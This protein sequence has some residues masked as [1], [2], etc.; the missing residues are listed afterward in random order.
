V[1]H[2][3]CRVS[4]ADQNPD[5]QR[6]ALLRA[7]VHPDQLY[8]DRTSG[9]KSSR[10]ARDALCKALRAGDVLVATRLDRVGRSTTHLVTLLDQLAGRGVAFRFL[11]QGIDTTTSEGRLMYRMLAAIA[12]FQRDL[13]IANTREGLA[14]ARARGR[15]GGRKPKLTGHQVQ[16]AQQLYDARDKTVA[17]IAAIFTVPRTTIYGHLNNGSAGT[18]PRARKPSAPITE[19]AKVADS[20]G[21]PG[22]VLRPKPALIPQA[23]DPPSAQERALHER[24]VRQREA[25]RASRCPTCGNEPVEAQIRWRQRQDL[26]II[27]LHLNGDELREQRHCVA[28]QP[29]DQPVIIEC[30]R[31]G[32]GPLVTGLPAN[33]PIDQWPPALT[34]WL[35]NNGWRTDPEPRCGNHR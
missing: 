28:C 35:H 17:E 27:W 8:L 16:L 10:P 12:E 23:D 18:R 29:H 13:I 26:A 25:M 5:A 24:L 34:R 21:S 2:G 4:T 3:Y 30:D 1:L 22:A 7:G 14:A 15:K 19:P 20:A 33:T 6:D 32:D 9:A 11:E 31:C